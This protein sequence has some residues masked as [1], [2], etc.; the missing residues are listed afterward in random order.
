M[1]RA[2][3][4]EYDDR[5]A[6]GY[7]PN[8]NPVVR[9]NEFV[10]PSQSSGQG[11]G[12]SNL[13]DDPYTRMYEQL[14]RNQIGRLSQPFSDPALDEVVGLIRS[15]VGSMLSAAP[16]SF[17]AGNPY[18]GEYAA[19]VRQRMGELNQE[20]FSAP[21]EARM[22]TKAL[23]SVEGNRSANLQRIRENISRRGIADTSGIMLDME[24]SA[25]DEAAR[26]RT[27]AETDLAQYIT[28]ERNR[29]RDQAVTLGGSL[30]QLGEAE[31]GRNLSAQIASHNANQS[32]EGQI[33]QAAGMLA[34]LAAQRRGEVR[35]RES[36]VL[37][38]ANS[39]ASLTPQRLALA[40]SVLNGTS[41]DLSSIFGNTLS[42]SNSQT[43]G[44]QNSQNA[45]NNM[46][47]GLAQIMGYM[48]GG[49]RG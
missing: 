21:E 23:E 20:P 26:N 27:T 35:A 40:M 42:L 19:A 33:F 1:A 44:R 8:P 48:A 18:M 41:P 38:I 43:A 37:Q 39:L 49:Q 24:R 16:V 15:R 2:N 22:R 31:A 14:A 4:Y 29:R 47:M 36:D 32:R 28:S 17:N 6:R 30:A 3:S 9:P 11:S 5:R 34:E 10:Q 46:L 13:F 45:T 25:N 7:R 12:D